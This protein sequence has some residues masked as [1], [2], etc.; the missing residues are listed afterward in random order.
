MTATAEESTTAQPHE[1]NGRI[2][3]V[4]GPS[5]SYARRMSETRAPGWTTN[6][7]VSLP[8]PPLKTMSM[9]GQRSR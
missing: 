2:V 9:P 6:S 4:I 1:A 7:Y 3:R 8:A 5:P